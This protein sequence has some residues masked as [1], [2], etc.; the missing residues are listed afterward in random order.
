MDSR[1][2]GLGMKSYIKMSL[3]NYLIIAETSSKY[4]IV[5]VFDL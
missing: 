1:E 5:F 3:E 2:Y 4:I